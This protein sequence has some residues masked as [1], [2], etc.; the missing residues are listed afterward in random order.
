[1]FVILLV[2]AILMHQGCLKTENLPKGGLR[3]HVYSVFGNPLS[4][5]R[6]YVPED[7]AY[8]NARG[9]YLLESLT[10]QIYTLTAQ[11]ETFETVTQRVEVIPG[12][13]S[14][15]VNF[16][17]Q[18]KGSIYSISVFSITSTAAEIAFNTVEWSETWIEY[19]PNTQYG[20]TTQ[21]TAIQERFHSASLTNLTPSTTYHFIIHAIDTKGRTVTSVNRTFTTLTTTRGNPPATLNAAKEMFSDTVVLNWSADTGGDLAG[22]KVYR[23]NAPTGP[24]DPLISGTILQN[25]FNDTNV[26]P[27]NKYYYRVTRV[28][29]TGEESPPSPT[30]E[31]LVPGYSSQNLVWVPEKSPYLLTG[32]LIISPGTSLTITPGTSVLVKNRDQWKSSGEKISIEIR[33]TLSVQGTLANPVTISSAETNPAA[34]DWTGI[35]FTSTANLNTSKVT[36]LVLSFATN[37]IRGVAGIPNITDSTIANCLEAAIDCRAARSPVVISNVMVDTCTSGFILIGNDQSVSVSSSRIL[38]CFYG[39]VSRNNLSSE[40]TDNRIQFWGIMGMDLGNTRTSSRASRNIVAPGSSG[41]AVVLRGNDILQRNTL[42]GQIGIEIIGT[43]SAV[44]RSNLILADNRKSAI[45]VLYRGD[46]PYSTASQ[47]IQSNAIWDIPL[48]EPRRYI[49]DQGNALTGIGSDRRTDPLLEGG[50]PF[51]DLPSV[52]F[53][54]IPTKSSGLKGIG[55]G[56]EDIG[57][58]DVPR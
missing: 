38:R 21:R 33:D 30:A 43:A 58:H 13:I 11:K 12:E 25:S 28:S 51:V 15:R 44:I 18:E 47:T 34:G 56:G 57:A 42:Q 20:Q 9:E 52:N 29:G 26:S 14:E 6:V 27:G 8:T 7:Y 45:G 46:N 22:Y 41:S 50:S 53:S 3:G 23:S 2:F 39:I 32:T 40:I 35:V 55:Y 1:M 36:G 19:G 37:G 4:G 54:Y 17:L 49:D 10:P 16:T 24:F 5:V 48:G 31:F